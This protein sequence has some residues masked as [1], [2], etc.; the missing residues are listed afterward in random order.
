MRVLRLSVSNFLS[1]GSVSVD[2]ASRGMILVDGDNRDQPGAVS[3]GAG[4]SSIFTESLLWALYGTTSR[5]VDADGVIHRKAGRD[6]AVEVEF[7]V[8]SIAYRVRR[9]RKHAQD[10][11]TVRLWRAADELTASSVAETTKRIA[12]VTGLDLHTFMHS[13][14]LGQGLHRKFTALSDTDR[15]SV[16]EGI[17]HLTAFDDAR[18]NVRKALAETSTE[19]V[20]LRAVIDAEKGTY[21]VLASTLNKLNQVPPAPE[22]QR[23]R[24]IAEAEKALALSQSAYDTA[25]AVPLPSEGTV[26]SDIAAVGEQIASLTSTIKFVDGEVATAKAELSLRTLRLNALLGDLK[27]REGT[28]STPTCVTCE[29]VVPESHR[30]RVLAPLRQ[31]IEDARAA[32]ARAEAAYAAPVGVLAELSATLAEHEKKLP[33]LRALAQKIQADIQS[34]E[35]TIASRAAELERAKQ[36]LAYVRS[37]PPPQAQTGPD[38]AAIADV[39]EKMKAATEKIQKAESSLRERADMLAIDE[40]VEQVYQRARSK[41]LEDALRFLNERIAEYAGVLSDGTVS[42]VLTAT[43]AT[44]AGDVSDRI[45]LQVTTIGGSYASAS[46][47]EADRIDF[48]IA[49]AIHDLVCS[50]AGANHNLFVVDEPANFVD[51]AGLQRIAQLLDQKLATTATIIVVSQ[52]PAFRGLLGETWVA[53]KEGGFTRLEGA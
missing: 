11:S 41:G 24:L 8:D 19:C 31:Q 10:G 51:P 46:G 43:T 6:C 48:A 17:L 16:L 3:N 14:V 26:A 44:K 7:E 29:Q 45:G 33:P 52:N 36:G 15:K 25:C 39:T 1:V 12:E 28:L 22:D 13:I 49:L 37:L 40:V 2:L 18:K 27:S 9:T 20:K 38:P 30:E 47:G 4:K 34:R 50:A 42:A 21:Q 23:P 5:G 53:V 32:L 35:R